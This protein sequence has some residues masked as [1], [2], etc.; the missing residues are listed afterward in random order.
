MYT[1]IQCNVISARIANSGSDD[2]RHFHVHVC[3][4][5][6]TSCVHGR[7]RNAIEANIADS[8]THLTAEVGGVMLSRKTP[9]SAYRKLLKGARSPKYEINLA[10]DS[11]LKRHDFKRDFT[12]MKCASPSSI[13]SAGCPTSRHPDITILILNMCMYPCRRCGVLPVQR[14]DQDRHLARKQYIAA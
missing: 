3:I 14:K 12:C 1:S 8:I 11:Q 9:P 10:A 6:C 4:Y 7:N 13:P 5:P 2:I